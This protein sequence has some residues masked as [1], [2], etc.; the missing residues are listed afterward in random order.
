MVQR[1]LDPTAIID[2]MPEKVQ[3]YVLLACSAGIVQ[4]QIYLDQISLAEEE[5]TR[6]VM[7]IFYVEG[8]Q[9]MYFYAE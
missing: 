1:G 7:H 8:T 6:V 3:I 2:Y 4:A 9:F 5:N